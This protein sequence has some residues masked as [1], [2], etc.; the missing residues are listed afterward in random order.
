MPAACLVYDTCR[1]PCNTNI[2]SAAD[3]W[4]IYQDLVTKKEKLDDVVTFWH[5]VED[6]LPE[7]TVLAKA[8]ITLALAVASVDVKHSFS[9]YRSVLSPLHHNLS[10]DISAAYCSVFTIIKL[11]DF[12]RFER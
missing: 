9:E 8:Y 1:F 10:T 6:R 12:K 4:L 7:L 5:A 3:E 11:T 2:L